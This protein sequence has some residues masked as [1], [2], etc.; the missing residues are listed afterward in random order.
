[1]NYLNYAFGDPLLFY[2]V[3]NDFGAQRETGRIVMLYQVFWR[4]VKMLLTV[5]VSSL[6][7]Y[8]VILEFLAGLF[9]LILSILS[10]RDVRKSY[11]LF[12][13]L[14]YILPTLTGTF[15]S[16]PRY[17]LPLFPLFVVLSKRLNP[18]VYKLTL[19]LL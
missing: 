8:R 1:M 18:L 15:S 19:G 5:K 2:S 17:V 10:F 3:Q 4:Y 11:A 16:M 6:L 7:Y 13:F 12:A 9:G 14:A